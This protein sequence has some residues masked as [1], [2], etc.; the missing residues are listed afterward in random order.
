MKAKCLV[1]IPIGGLCNRMRVMA[2]TMQLAEQ[3]GATPYVFWVRN[4]EL[5]AHFKDL[6][7]QVKGCKV[8]EVKEKWTYRVIKLLKNITPPIKNVYFI[9]DKNAATVCMGNLKS[10]VEYLKQQRLIVCFTCCNLTLTEDFS[11]FKPQ[12]NVPMYV[13]KTMVGVHIRRTDNELSKK[14]SPTSLFVDKMIAI[15][16]NEAKTK[17][18]LATDDKDEE[19]YFKSLFPQKIYTHKKRSYDRNNSLAIEDALIDLYNLAQC[20][21]ILAS[22]YSSFSDVA[23]WWGKI[24]KEVVH[25]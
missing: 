16:N 5:N 20:R 19:Q 11:M 4:R 21:E 24:E 1:S 7:V 25:T 6:F 2:S 17:F 8:Y 15:L 13:D 22:Y 10:N 14:Y 3:I 12:N 9:D 23:A 18:Y